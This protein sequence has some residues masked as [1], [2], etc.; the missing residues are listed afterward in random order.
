MDLKAFLGLNAMHCRAFAV[1]R[2]SW[3]FSHVLPTFSTV[4]VRLERV[5]AAQ[6]AQIDWKL[7]LLCI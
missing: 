1:F 7:V 3:L 4:F 2:V 6:K 5:L